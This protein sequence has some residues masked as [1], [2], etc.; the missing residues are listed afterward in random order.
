MLK[1]H[2][3]ALLLAVF[4]VTSLAGCDTNDGP[5]ESAGERV[6]DAYENTKDGVKDAADN[7]GDAI[8]DA[9]DEATDGNC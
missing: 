1:A 9:C 6:D 7:A 2:V 5:V 3:F 4:G 8:D